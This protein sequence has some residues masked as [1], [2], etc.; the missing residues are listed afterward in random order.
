MTPID[1]N[2]MLKRC[3][4]DKETY[5]VAAPRPISHLSTLPVDFK[6]T[7]GK[8]GLLMNMS[9]CPFQDRINP[10]TNPTPTD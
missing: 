3:K 1:S 6:I 9:I 5:A 2:K 8:L 10:K 4:D 7:E